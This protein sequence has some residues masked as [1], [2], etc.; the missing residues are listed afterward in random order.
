[1]AVQ[2]FSIVD[3]IKDEETFN[4]LK[5]RCEARGQTNTVF[6]GRTWEEFKLYKM[7]G[8]FPAWAER[9]PEAD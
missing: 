9:R 1:M 7:L 3:F 2:S 4:F 5:A 8:F 6:E